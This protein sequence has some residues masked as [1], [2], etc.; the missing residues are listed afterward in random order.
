MTR[1]VLGSVFLFLVT[2][3]SVP[4]A[5]ADPIIINFQGLHDMQAIGNYY[6]GG[7]GTNF[8]VTFSSNIFALRPAAQGGIGNF[9][10]DP[11]GSPAMFIDGAINSKATGII[12][13][14]GG[15]NTG[16]SFFY[17]AAFSQTVTVWS[18]A[19][20]T[21]TILATI[22]LSPNDANCVT[23]PAYCNWSGVGLGF[24]GSAKS[25]TIAGAGNGIGISD[26]SIGSTALAVPEPSSLV[27]LGTGLIGLFVVRRH[28]VGY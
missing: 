22:A 2:L 13:V 15:F 25:I 16:I 21:G 8:G 26:L 6:D 28:L 14:N 24:S 20:G 19:N 9:S 18:G 7:G 11:I 1:S 27:L 5:Q 10:A 3:F 4:F 12:N 23:G 17:T